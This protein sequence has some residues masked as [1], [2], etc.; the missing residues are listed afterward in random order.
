MNRDEVL[1]IFAG[2][3]KAFPRAA[4]RAAVEQEGEIIPDLLRIVEDTVARAAEI[5]E[6]DKEG[7]NNQH[8]YALYLLAQ[9]REPRAYPLVVALA[10]LDEALLDGLVGDFITE[11]LCQV[12]ASVCDGDR[13]PL[14]ATVEDASVYEY[15]R[16]AALLALSILV[17]EGLMPRDELV[18]YFKALFEG[19]LEREP[20][21]VW[22]TLVSESIAL[23]PD[24]LK[25]YILGAFDDDLVDPWYVRREALEKAQKRSREERDEAFARRTPSLITDVLQDMP[26]WG[27]GGESKPKKVA[28]SETS[29]L[30]LAPKASGPKIGRNEPCPC[31]S[32]KKYKKCCLR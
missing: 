22:C 21:V 14:E 16:D 24:E 3:P 10:R 26:Q 17:K 29:R 13:R 27:Y 5:V 30:V 32:G 28:K 2:R 11:D 7:L 25:G 19:K 31:G 4:L 12:L 8:M 20:S 6:E 15:A 9:F 23:A 1:A 18:A